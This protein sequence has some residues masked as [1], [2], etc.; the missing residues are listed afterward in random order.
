M[1]SK[2]V[3]SRLKNV[4]LILIGISKKTKKKCSKKPNILVMNNIY[5]YIYIYNLLDLKTFI[6]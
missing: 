6:K 5:I 1:N 4:C 2:G 3:E